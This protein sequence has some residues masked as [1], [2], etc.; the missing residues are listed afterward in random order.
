MKPADLH[1]KIFLDSGDPEE[2]KKILE[3]LG[4]LDGQTTNPSLIAKNPEA[5]A[6]IESGNLF[7]ADEVKTFYKKVVGE[8]SSLIPEGSVSVEV[9]ADAGT[10]AEEMIEEAQ[11]M[12]TW[13]PNAHIK[14][15]TT[16]SG[17]EAA[18]KLT[19]DGMRVN[20]TLTFSQEQAAA[21]HAAT[22]GA[23]RGDVFVSPFIGRLDDKGKQGID[24]VQNI[25]KMF[26]LGVSHV[27]VLAASVRTLEHLTKV[28]EAEADIVTAPFEVLKDWAEA[29]MP[30]EFEGDGGAELEKIEYETISLTNE[31]NAYDIS[32]EL[33]D[34][35]LEKFAADWNGMVA[36]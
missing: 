12:N 4:F 17:L 28:F 29:G 5:Q 10:K 1:T 22:R 20:M 14:L 23:D 26:S 9:Y 8:I 33:T 30:L 18:E 2:T 36:K 6:R 11:E 27:E 13:I 19:G 3:I 24:V 35:G 16:A 32:H 34:A 15:P 21:V 25:D 31:W 7:S